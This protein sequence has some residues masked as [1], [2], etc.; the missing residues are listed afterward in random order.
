M[1]LLAVMVVS[2][3][4]EMIGFFIGIHFLVFSFDIASN[5][6]AIIFKT[7][8]TPTN[9]IPRPNQTW[10]NF[11][12][13][14]C[15]NI[16]RNRE[17]VK[18][19][20]WTLVTASML[21]TFLTET[22]IEETEIWKIHYCCHADH[23][24]L[25]FYLKSLLTYGNDLFDSGRDDHAINTYLLVLEQMTGFDPKMTHPKAIKDF[26]LTLRKLSSCFNKL[27]R[28]P[29][30]SPKRGK[31]RKTFPGQYRDG[32]QVLHHDCKVFSKTQEKLFE[33]T[34]PF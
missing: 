18:S 29:L 4:P 21:L 12:H 15:P 16:R 22:G 2:F 3:L 34:E 31:P 26:N 10:R 14:W 25:R 7:A 9:D 11:E 33:F 23:L 30:T 28:E 27:L 6:V 20:V 13:F 32:Y 8:M 24:T 19:E 17:I 1:K 5:V